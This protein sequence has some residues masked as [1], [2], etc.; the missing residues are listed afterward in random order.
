[1]NLAPRP[2]MSAILIAI[3]VSLPSLAF[4]G[5]TPEEVAAFQK[6]QKRNA[7]A[8]GA[9]TNTYWGITTPKEKA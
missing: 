3:L 4:A 8:G 7:A 5:M 1:M 6:A 9:L 2:W